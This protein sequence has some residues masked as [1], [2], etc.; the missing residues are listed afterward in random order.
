MPIPLGPIAWGI[1][2]RLLNVGRP[3]HNWW[4][5][6]RLNRAVAAWSSVDFPLLCD[7]LA[8]YYDFNGVP[9]FSYP[10]SSRK[11]P[12]YVRQSWLTLSETS[13]VMTMVPTE[14]PVLLNKKASAFLDLYPRVRRSLGLAQL[15]NGRVF[16]LIKLETSDDRLKLEFELGHFF[17]GLASQYVLEHE[18]RLAL[19]GRS[20]KRIQSRDL[21]L[22]ESLAST[23]DAIE[24]FCETQFV[25]IGV[26]NLILF[27]ADKDTYRPAIRVRGTL[28]M[29]HPGD[30]D[31]MSSG[32]LDISTHDPGFDF[33]VQYK[34]L[35]EIYEEL[36]GGKEVEKEML[37]LDPDFFFEKPPIKDLKIMLDDG[38]ASLRLTGFC[39]DLVRI[40]P[41][42]T[43]VLVVRDESYYA[44]YQ[45]KFKVNLEYGAPSACRIPRGI[46]DVD[47]YLVNRFPSNPGQPNGDKGFDSSKWTLPGGFCFYQGLK[48]AVNEELL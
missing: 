16:R 19:S 9:L 28:S 4:K 21:P 35:K 36:F 24:R 32:I 37:G 30:F 12:L 47:E 43:T 23:P 15:W 33:N 38:R 45:G 20:A 7:S 48:R 1:L 11:V 18:A 44:K 3:L 29:G 41:E 25:R 46:V 8:Q 26:S 5:R 17:D 6:R 31:P 42:I 10:G 13:L 27:R 22:R 14:R 39:I 2:Q 40:V 34:V